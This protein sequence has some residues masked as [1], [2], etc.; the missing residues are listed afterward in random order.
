MKV[1]W[2]WQSDTPGKIGRYFVRDALI[3]AIERLKETPDVQ[4]PTEREIRSTMHLDQDRKGISGS[5]DLGFCQHLRQLA[6][7]SRDGVRSW[8]F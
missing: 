8:P 1:F 6:D 5:P 3:A 7:T 4:E 2:S